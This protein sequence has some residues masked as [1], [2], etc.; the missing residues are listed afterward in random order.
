MLFSFI[1]AQEVPMQERRHAQRRRFGY[2]MPLVDDKTQELVGHLADIS[3]D[4][5]K[6][7]STVPIPEGKT[8]TLRLTLTGEISHKP[9]MSF[10]AR[11]KWCKADD[12]QPNSYYVGFEV[13]S[14]SPESAEIFKR[15]FEKYGS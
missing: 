8:Y 9:W 3:K 12:V 6:L 2:Y 7:D 11:S 4:G 10:N 13:G 5:F 15:I 14:M 1:A